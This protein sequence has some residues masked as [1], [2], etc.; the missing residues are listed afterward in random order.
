MIDTRW[1]QNKLA[2]RGLSQ[3]ALARRLG[4][5][6]A[7]V[8]LMLHGRR[9]MSAK[10]AAEVA[11]ALGVGID[12]VVTRAG[13]SGMCAIGPHDDEPEGDGHEE[14][15]TG[16]G[17]GLGVGVGVGVGY[18]EVPVPLHGGGV[19]RVILPRRLTRED[20]ERIAA[21]VRAFAA[22]D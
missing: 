20:A 17:C 18:L 11:G 13:L 12:A 21:I 19:A 22:G 6:P 4:L 16:P 10:E 3:R 1:F 15:T 7:A 2:D 5:D 8:S 9:N 14:D